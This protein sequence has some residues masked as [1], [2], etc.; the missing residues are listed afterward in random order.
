MHKPSKDKHFIKQPW[1]EGGP[2]A[3]KQFVAENLR[4]PKEALEQRLEGTV[5]VRY[6]IDHEGNV[7]DAKIIGHGLGHGCDEEAIR[8]VRSMKFKVDKPRGLRVIYHNTIQIHFK[9]PQVVEQPVQAQMQLN[10]QTTSTPRTPSTQEK[11][12][13]SYSYDVSF[14]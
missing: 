14:E 10:Y 4:Y 3:M 5:S 8:L 13:G 1:F 12:P 2:K 7:I 11:K 6:D 9:L